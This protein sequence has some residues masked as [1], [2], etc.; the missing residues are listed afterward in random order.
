MKLKIRRDQ[1]SGMMGGITFTLDMM[2]ELSADEV[3]L[4]HKYKLSNQTVYSSDKAD[5]NAA[6][7]EG[8]SLAGVAALAMDRL[9]K[10]FFTVSDLMQGQHVES[11]ELDEIL[12]AE[13][14]IRRACQN[15]RGYLEAA[16]SFDGSEQI[17]EIAG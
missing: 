16:T 6:R 1:K 7:A 8:G 14:Q 17:V 10:K 5:A 2:A 4:V 11:K 15:L 13:A 12:A 3:A 9:T